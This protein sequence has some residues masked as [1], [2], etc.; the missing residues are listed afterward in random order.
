[1]PKLPVVDIM[2]KQYNQES[3]LTK[4][5]LNSVLIDSGTTDC[6]VSA[7]SLHSAPLTFTNL[8]HELYLSNALN[9]KS[10]RVIRKTLTCNIKIKESDIELVNC[11]FYVV[12]HKMS[13]PAILGMSVLRRLVVNFSTKEI[14]LTNI[15]S[16]NLRIS[17]GDD[18]VVKSGQLTPKYPHVVCGAESVIGPFDEKYIECCAISC[19]AFCDKEE[20]VTI[21]DVNLSS[22]SISVWPKYSKSRNLIKLKNFTE[23]PVLIE[24]GATLGKLKSVLSDNLLPVSYTHLTLPTKA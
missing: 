8:A 2:L 15:W 11:T 1:M 9:Q 7:E 21:P 3:I 20:L 4:I 13:F 14:K 24:K 23:H 5:N 22:K 18:S 17:T 19:E 16:N 12:E 6:L 10:D